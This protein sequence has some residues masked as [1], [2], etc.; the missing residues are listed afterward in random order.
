VKFPLVTSFF[1]ASAIFAGSAYVADKVALRISYRHSE[2]MA[3]NS[4][5]KQDAQ[6]LRTTLQTLTLLSRSHLV[7]RH[8]PSTADYYTALEGSI[9]ALQKFRS[10]APERLRPLIDLQLAIDY[11]EM[12]QFEQKIGHVSQADRARQSAQEL[13]GHLGWKDVSEGALNTL[14]DQEIEPV[15]ISEDKK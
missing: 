14:A 9:P 11:A 3:F 10:Q 12:A 15:Q 1:I 7:T 8:E 5:A 4:L 13:L 6:E 2:S